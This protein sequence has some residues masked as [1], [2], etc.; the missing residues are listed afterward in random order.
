MPVVFKLCAAALWGA[1]RNSKGAAIFFQN[2]IV[3]IWNK[4]PKQHFVTNF[5]VPRKF[6][7]L[8]KG[9]ASKKV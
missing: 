9:A 1:A 6:S 2:Q 8:F 4:T 7:G 5:G 3:H